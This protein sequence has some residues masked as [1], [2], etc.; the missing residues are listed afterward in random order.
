[1]TATGTNG[2]TATASVTVTNNTVNPTITAAT[3]PNTSCTEIKNGSITLSTNAATFRWDNNLSA[4]QNQTDLAAGTYNVTATG[5]N[6]CTATASVTVT[7]NTVNPTITATPLPNTRCTGAQTGSIT[8]STNATTFAWNNN[9][10]ATQNQIGL[11]AG[12]YSV[13]ATGLD[14]CTVATSATVTNSTV[15]PVTSITGVTKICSGTSTTLSAV[16]GFASY[17][18]SDGTTGQSLLAN[19]TGVYTLTVTDNNNCTGSTTHSLTVT[20]PIAATMTSQDM[21]CYGDRSG[22]F[23]FTNITGGTSPYQLSYDNVILPNY[24]ANQVVSNLEAGNYLVTLTDA[25]NCSYSAPAFTINEPAPLI[26]TTNF[27]DS[28]IGLGDSAKIIA[29]IPLRPSDYTA[30]WTPSTTLSCSTCLNPYAKPLS[31]TTYT[32]TV[33]YNNGACTATHNVKVQADRRRM[34]YIPSGFTPNGDGINDL[35]SIFGT[36]GAIKAQKI[37]IYDRWG[38][39][40]YDSSLQLVNDQTIGWD[41]TFN[42]KALSPDVFVYYVEVVFADGAVEP[43]KGDISIVR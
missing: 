25:N 36:N 29:S 9:L 32:L 22:Q 16:G 27:R 3:T 5:T 2:C 42:G 37:L 8:L 13:T 18:W 15:T 33:N 28:I 20:D 38:E 4:T 17:R 35:F 40:I 34:V 26:I 21:L 23:L 43:Y 31:T 11:A 12:I 39:K 6:G 41:G 7:S 30:V 10:P 24:K 19:R 1:V 14:G